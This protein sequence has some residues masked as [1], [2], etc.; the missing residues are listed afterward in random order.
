MTEFAKAA[1]GELTKAAERELTAEELDHIAGGGVISWLRQLYCDY[2]D[3]RA[4]QR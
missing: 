1:E 2:F 4:C 3:P